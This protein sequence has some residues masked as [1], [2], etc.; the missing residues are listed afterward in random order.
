MTATLALGA[1]AAFAAEGAGQS[2][3][4]RLRL[5]HFPAG[6]NGFFRAPVLLTGPT[7]SL[8]VDG[9]FT[10]PDGQVL[11]EAIRAEGKPL[12]AVYVS[13]SDPDYYFSL[14]P[15]LAVF[16]NAR[17]LAAPETIAAIRGNVEKKLAAWG[18]Q[19][20]ANGP[21]SLADIT[22]PE[23]H[24][25]P[26][27]TVDGETVEIVPAQAGLANRRHLRIPSLNAVLGGVLVF[28]GV[29]VWTAD[30]QRAEERAA[31]V[32]SLDAIAAVR[33][34]LVVPGHMA[35]GAATDL[36][37]VAFTRAY[38]LAFEDELAKA[39]D[40]AAL[41]AIME[42]RFPGLGMGVALDIGSKVAK[43]EMTWG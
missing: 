33:P 34:S 9:G 24:S 17:V 29:H 10:F 41:K 26:T 11:A 7:E 12:K 1:A 30:T 21:R 3:A 32:A 14:K 20:G 28:S 6:P 36:S 39:A 15:V 13:Q 19:L 18:P 31:W 23:P 25:A 16:P 38:L 40:G 22:M 43:G 4:P 27:L 37:A 2:A 42:A 35:P 5:R 8:L